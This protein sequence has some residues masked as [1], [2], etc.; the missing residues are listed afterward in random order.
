MY[1]TCTLSYITH[2][3]FL[4]YEDDFFPRKELLLLRVVRLAFEKQIIDVDGD[5]LMQE[6]ERFLMVYSYCN[7]LG[8]DVTIFTG[9]HSF[10]TTFSHFPNA[11]VHGDQ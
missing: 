2:S 4:S 3:V 9:L 5:T 10:P 1:T 7:Y 8:D 6:N 11:S